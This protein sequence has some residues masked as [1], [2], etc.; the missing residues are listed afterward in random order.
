VIIEELVKGM[1]RELFRELTF[2]PW[3]RENEKS[4]LKA[5]RAEEKAA[6]NYQKPFTDYLDAEEAAQFRSFWD[7]HRLPLLVAFLTGMSNENLPLQ[8]YE[9]HFKLWRDELNRGAHFELE[10]RSHY[11]N[12]QRA[13]QGLDRSLSMAY[14]KTMRGYHD[15][16]RPLLGRYRSLRSQGGQ[17]LEKHLASAFYPK[18][19]F[20]YGR[21]QAYRQAAPQGSIFKLVTAYAAL[22]QRYEEIGDPEATYAQL[23]PLEIVDHTHKRGKE[24]YIGYDSLGKPIPRSYKGG[25][26]PRSSHIIGK[27]D[28]MR[29]IETSS[30]PYFSLLAGD[31][32][33][34]PEDLELAA[35]NFSYGAKTGIALPAEIAGQIPVDLATNLTGLYATAIGQH[36]LVV[37]P[38]QTALMLASIANGGHVMH[39]QII[40]KQMN[41]PISRKEKWSISL[42]PSIREILLESMRRVV[43]KTQ[44]DSL[45]RLSRIYRD[46][47]EAISDYI[48]LKESLIG[49]TSTAEMM[50]TVS[51]DGVYGTN[52]YKHVWFGGISFEDA[53]KE[54]PELV[55]VI[56]L[57]FGTYGKEAAP[58]A[59]QMVKKWREIN[60]R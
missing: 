22:K 10:W 9:E 46:Y 29:A 52:L 47:P 34:S 21:S 44:A 25:R 16:D 48:E 57:R 28:L 3:R 41:E 45:M 39:P 15:L 58:L 35:R 4:Y 24:L 40:H 20:S 33:N 31:V 32:L 7:Q 59:A 13:L 6:K 38:L 60:G 23:N 56:Y 18:N 43:V 8:E 37:T 55:V 51:L 11:F 50:E 17:Q 27:L 5:K 12:I 49:K 19:G 2:K 1:A 26:I 30:N 54:H 36:T 14:L 42:P 53:A